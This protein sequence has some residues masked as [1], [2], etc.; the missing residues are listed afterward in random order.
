MDPEL[1]RLGE[2]AV[3]PGHA[4]GRAED[5]NLR[6]HR[7]S[8]LESVVAREGL[9]PVPLECSGRARERLGNVLAIAQWLRQQ[10][11]VQ[12]N[13]SGGRGGPSSPVP[14][15]APIPPQ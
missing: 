13:A 15:D 9:A 12:G 5:R 1:P 2:P 14:L 3:V 6:N 11:R 7:A 10:R 4:A 8:F